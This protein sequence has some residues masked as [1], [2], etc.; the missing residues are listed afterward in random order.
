MLPAPAL[1]AFTGALVKAKLFES[2]APAD[3]FSF[4]RYLDLLDT[5]SSRHRT[6]FDDTP[7]FQLRFHLLFTLC[8][9]ETL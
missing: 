5:F 8:C 4:V 1:V 3:Y 2:L 9:V 7:E 6:L